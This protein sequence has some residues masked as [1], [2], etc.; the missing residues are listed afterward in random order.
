M[1]CSHCALLDGLLYSDMH[2]PLLCTK[3]SLTESNVNDH[4][5]VMMIGTYEATDLQC[6]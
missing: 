6:T 1:R 2:A 3:S 4:S 5:L